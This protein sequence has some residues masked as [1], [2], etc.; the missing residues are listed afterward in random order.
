MGSY[1]DI[2][3]RSGIVYL[4]MLIAI[5]IFGKR[6][7]SQLNTADVILILLVSNSVQNAMVGQDTTLVGG[8][9]AAFIL[10]L[11]NYAI[12]KVMVHSKTFSDIVQGKPEILIYKGRMDV[13]N[14]ADLDIS[15]D[16]LKEAVREHGME[17]I[18]DVKL[19][20][21]EIDGNLSIME[22]NK[23]IKVW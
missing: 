16:E 9:I 12:K 18:S 11:L 22:K 10:F 5:R 14:L 21:L 17:K 19:A 6:E 1:L 2:I 20:I 8:L 13:Q 4:F 15:I 3:I 23:R 7:L